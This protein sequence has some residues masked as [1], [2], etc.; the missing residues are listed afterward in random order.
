MQTLI[1]RHLTGDDD[2]YRFQ[3]W[4]S[5][6]KSAEPVELTAPD[7]VTVEGRPNSNLSVELRWYLEQFLEYPFE[8]LTE[9]A[10]RVQAALRGWGEQTFTALFGAGR[11]R[12]FY[13]D[14]Y[15]EGL[16]HLTLKIAS[17]DPKVLAWPWEALRDPEAIPLAHACQFE[18]QLSGQHDPLPLPENLPRERINI[19]LITARPYEADVGFRTLSRP[20]LELIERERLPANIDML[21][22]P[23]F[24]Q[25]RRCLSERKGHYHIVHFDGH[26]GYGPVQ[27]GDG[28]QFKQG[29]QGQLIFETEDGS[30]DLIGAETLATLL[31]EY[32]VP[33]MVLNACQSAMIDAG[34]ENAFA[35][36]AASLQRAGVRSVVAMAYS[37]YVSAAE[38]FIPPFYERLFASGSVTEAVRAGRQGLLKEAGRTCAR[39]RFPLEDWLVPVVYQQDPPQIDFAAQGQRAAEAD[40]SRLPPEIREDDN[41]YGFIGRDNALLV[42]ERALRRPPPGI[43]IHG[44]G[45]VGK[46]TLAKGLVHWLNDTG[47]LEAG[48]FWFTFADIRS[49]EYM[50]NRLIE[51]LVGVNATAAPLDQK[52][53]ALLQALKDHPFLLI[54]DNFETVQGNPEAGIEPLLPAEDREQLREF[55]YQLRGGKTKVIITSRS[56]ESAWLNRPNCYR[57]PLGGL[58]S[59]E[60]WTYCNA[61]VRDLGLT[62]KRDDQ[63]LSDL[64]DLLDGHP[65]AMRVM[66]V[67]LADYSAAALSQQLR[68]RLAQTDL[69]DEAQAKLFAT[70]GFVTEALPDDLKPLLTPLALHERFVDANYLE[71]MAKA[72]QVPQDR[73]AID[74]LLSSLETAGLVH[75]HGQGIYGLHPA[76][77]GFLHARATDDQT[78]AEVAWRRAFVNFMGSFADQLAQKQLH[79]QRAPF[80][81]HSANFHNAIA[82]AEDLRISP[83]FA[84]LIQALAIYAQYQRDFANARRYSEQLAEHGRAH[85]NPKREALAYHRLGNLAYLQRDFTQ[86]AQWYHKALAIFGKQGNE[87]DAASTYHQLGNLAYLQRDF[88]QAAQWYHKSLAIKEKQSNEHGAADAYHQLGRIAQEQ[89]DFTQAAQWYHNALA[90]EEKQGNEYHAASTYHQLGNL[91]Y[92][93]RDFAQAAQWYHKSLAIKEKQSNEHGAAFTY[94]QLGLLAQTQ[95][96]HVESGRW[97]LKA[98]QGFAKTQAPHYAQQAAQNFMIFYEQASATDQA[99]LKSL[100]NQAGLGPFPTENKEET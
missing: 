3:L 47:G 91:A 80:H 92:L 39:G 98:I 49:S 67:Q 5:D 6:G 7:A 35:S 90:I 33:I 46:T 78:S 13:K 53:A 87:H 17:D 64:M 89:R 54:W 10:E 38:Q 85:S 60:R 66:L 55:L 34:A 86:A 44:L 97:L 29:Y 37:L 57:L 21:R 69:A 61:I 83:A 41:P 43:L 63:Q 75:P 27:G 93:Q 11:G 16:E 100:W 32:R 1:V 20:L 71:T 50:F 4:R 19:L 15:R 88:A 2:T 94:A 65:L 8:P 84:A 48:C 23:T 81:W 95:Q 74:R 73:A 42:L 30:E 28:F 58:K 59:E 99:T 45:G 56:Q 72:V 68:E 70:L 77:T 18:R 36:V 51:A 62:V 14:A 82:L 79:E 25:L 22:P 26:G 76:L 52:C 40:T 96:D 9:R 31:S 24:E 12:D